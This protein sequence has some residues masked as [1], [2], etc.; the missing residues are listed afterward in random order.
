MEQGWVDN[1]KIFQ[2]RCL[3]LFWLSSPS[4]PSQVR[5]SLAVRSPTNSPHLAPYFIRWDT[6]AFNNTRY[7]LSDRMKSYYKTW[8]CRLDSVKHFYLKITSSTGCE[9]LPAS[10]TGWKVCICTNNCHALLLKMCHF[11]VPSDIFSMDIILN[12]CVVCDK[13]QVWQQKSICQEQRLANDLPPKYEDIIINQA[14][15]RKLDHQVISSDSN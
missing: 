10:S 5:A 3:V 6:K 7:Y 14:E 8:S 9:T 4:P 15:E 11:R 2:P 12:I 1:A 13:Y